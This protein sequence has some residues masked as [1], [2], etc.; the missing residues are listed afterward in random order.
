MIKCHTSEKGTPS[1]E[2]LISLSLLPSVNTDS[3]ASKSHSPDHRFQHQQGQRTWELNPWWHWKLWHWRPAVHHSWHLNSLLLWCF[4]AGSFEPA[5]W[6]RNIFSFFLRALALRPK[7]LIRQGTIVALLAPSLEL[8]NL[9][10]LR[11]LDHFL[12]Q[13]TWSPIPP[14][15]YWNS[16]GTY[17]SRA[18]RCFLAVLSVSTSYDSS[19]NFPW[20]ILGS[21]TKIN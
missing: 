6:D 16:T 2:G 17:I 9:G 18:I 11:L 4:S 1:D 7:A 21:F 14:I 20:G 3:G 13:H 12:S 15:S 8:K 10:R 19:I 5:A